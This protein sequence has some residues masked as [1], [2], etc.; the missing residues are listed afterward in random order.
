MSSLT[1]KPSEA[2]KKESESPL[3]SISAQEEST[4]KRQKK[5]KRVV[6][7]RERESKREWERGTNKMYALTLF[8]GMAWLVE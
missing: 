6:G 3:H 5:N 7:G 4:Q 8:V 1:P 2:S